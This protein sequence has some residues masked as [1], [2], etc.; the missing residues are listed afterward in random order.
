MKP[1]VIFGSIHEMEY[2]HEPTT[3]KSLVVGKIGRYLF[4]IMNVRGNHPTAYIHLPKGY[5][6]D[7][8]T[9]DWWKEESI[10]EVDWPSPLYSGIQLPVHGGLTY[11]GYSSSRK[12]SVVLGWDYGHCDDYSGNYGHG[13]KKWSVAEILSEIRD[14]V[15][16]LEEKRKE[17]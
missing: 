14:A 9:K 8:I 5:P 10:R 3:S 4:E 15:S 6:M 11:D 12:H 16:Y 2:T 13:E 1:V 17:A 7:N